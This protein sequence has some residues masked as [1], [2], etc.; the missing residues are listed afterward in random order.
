MRLIVTGTPEGQLIGSLIE[1]APLVGAEIV[2]IGK[3]ELDMSD[4]ATVAP[5]LER[6]EVDAVVNAAAYTAVDKA[7]SEEALAFRIN[8]EAAG[9]VAR[10]ARRRGLPLLHIS[11][12]YVFDGAAARPYREDDATGPT[13]AYGRTKLAGER[14]V[15]AN[16]PTATVLRTAWV[17][18]PFS[19]NFVKTM[20]RLSQCREEISVVA[21]QR[22]NPSYALDLADVVLSVARQR[23]ERRR[24]GFGAGVYHMTGSGEA[25]WADLAE[26]VFAE[27]ARLGRRPVKVKRIATNEYPT[28][29]KRPANSRLDNSKL[30][31]AFG[32]V[33]PEWRASARDCVR[34][35]LA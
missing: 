20:L 5:A 7:E 16:D 10:V 28:P 31:S 4:P 13:S 29:T 17:Y 24:D 25:T 27:A 35:L 26:E 6:I 19:V 21:D 9:E 1:R 33:L 22:G 32:V 30:A 2:A 34:R 8:G 11:T 18:S 15:L 3:P 14:L 23:V 12:D